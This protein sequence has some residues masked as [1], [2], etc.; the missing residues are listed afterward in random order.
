AITTLFIS[1]A[2]LAGFMAMMGSPQMIVPAQAQSA[3]GSENACK[4]LPGATLE[5]GRC[6]APADETTI[7]TCDPFFGQIP[8]P[9]GDKCT[10]SSTQKA[11]TETNNAIAACQAMPGGSATIANTGR[12]S[13]KIVTC[14]YDATVTIVYTCPNDIVPTDDHLCITKPGDRTEEEV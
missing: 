6:T 10:A 13:E 14:T 8:T 1:G 7:T 9:S 3:Q 2:L 11:G 5:R 12:P 4:E